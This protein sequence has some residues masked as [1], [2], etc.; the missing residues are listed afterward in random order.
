MISTIPLIIVEISSFA[1]ANAC[2][3]GRFPAIWTSLLLSITIT[4]SE[5]PLSCCKPNSALSTRARSI[6]KGVVTAP[7]TIEPWSFAAC[8]TT[9]AAPVPVP[10]PIPAQTKTISA[11]LSDSLSSASCS[12]AASMPMLA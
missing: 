11:P 3:T 12:F 6:V 5:T 4:V 2:W 7:M 8:A 1:T 9:G 10:P